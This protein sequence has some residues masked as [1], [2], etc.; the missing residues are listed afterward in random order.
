MGM[1]F[2][3]PATVGRSSVSVHDIYLSDWFQLAPDQ[4][5]KIRFR[6]W[7]NDDEVKA[8]DKSQTFYT[9]LIILQIRDIPIRNSNLDLRLPPRSCPMERH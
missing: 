2:A 5:K 7:N 3:P 9:R 4:H 1:E 8:V 6:A